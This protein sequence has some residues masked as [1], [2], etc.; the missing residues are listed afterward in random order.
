MPSPPR[1]STV[2]NTSASTPTRPLRTLPPPALTPAGSGLAGAAAATS[3]F[4]RGLTALTQYTERG[5]RIVVPRTHVEETPHGPVRLGTWIS[6]TRSRRGRLTSTQRAQLAA[7][8][9]A[10][11]AE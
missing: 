11:A 9:V 2:S 6:N 10:W 1:R 7:L 5:G 4:E 8:G 3:S